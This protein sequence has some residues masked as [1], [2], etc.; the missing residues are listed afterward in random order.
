MP[1]RGVGESELKFAAVFA[2]KERQVL[3]TEQ[4]E[5]R[6]KEFA[7]GRERVPEP[8]GPGSEFL[9]PSVGRGEEQKASGAY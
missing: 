7:D 3:A 6:G 2:K 5:V 8:A 1:D 9:G 4:T